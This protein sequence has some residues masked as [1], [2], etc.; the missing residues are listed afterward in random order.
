MWMFSSRITCSNAGCPAACP[1][2]AP[3]AMRFLPPGERAG[4]LSPRRSSSTLSRS[5]LGGVGRCVKHPPGTWAFAPGGGPTM[6]GSGKPAAEFRGIYPILYAFF[7]A[8]G[9]LDRA[10]MRAQARA[11]LRHGAHGVAALGLATEVGKL[12][13]A[14]RHQVLDWVT[15]DVAGRVPVAI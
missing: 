9:G 7:G 11:C 1:S 13:L 3:A 6:T 5:S 12:S 15:E 14:E 4:G 10:A 8:D 2:R